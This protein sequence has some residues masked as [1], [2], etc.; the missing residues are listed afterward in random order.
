MIKHILK[1]V[2]EFKKVTLL[3]PVFVTFEVILDVSIPYLMSIIIDRGIALGNMEIIVK[4]GTVLVLSALLALFCGILSGRCAAKA[5]AGLAKNLRHDL[6]Y[7]IQDFSFSDIDKF[8]TS[9][10]VTRLTTD[11]TNV[12]IAYQMIIRVAIRSPLML[13][14]ALLMSF[15]INSQI[16]L[17]FLVAIPFMGL[18]LYLLMSKAQPIIE[19]TIKIYD[20][21]NRVVQENLLGIRVVKAYVREDFEVSKFKSVSDDISRK[22]T[23]ADRILSLN[24]PLMQFT[25]YSCSLIL[26]WFGAT[27]IISS[28]MSTGQLMSLFS[29]ISQILMGLMMISMVLTMIIV[30]RTSAKRIVEVLD[31]QSSMENAKAPILSVADG[32]INFQNV[33]FSYTADENKLS[34]KNINLTINAGETIGIIGSTGSAKTTLIQLIPRLYE[35][36]VGSISVGGID[37][38][39]Y[40]LEVLRKSVAVV[41]QQNILFSGTIKENLRWGNKLAPDKEMVRVCK[42]AQ[43]DEF[44]RT[45]PKGY[46]TYIDQG[47]TNVSGGQKQRLCIARALLKKPQILIL[48]DSTSSVD[49]KTDE[50]IR[51]ALKNDTPHITKIIIAQRLS[52]IQDCDRIIVMD[53]GQIN[54]VG[55]HE[56]LIKNN[57]IYQEVYYSQLKGDTDGNAA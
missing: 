2:R 34:L 22:F 33:S 30:S 56:E 12:Q 50:L 49:T 43:A 28:T 32:S 10:L 19:K 13:L 15:R 51:C 16:A 53:A 31:T 52:S 24:S 8:S 48:D 36:T 25:M 26:S 47:G 40:D 42:I 6:Y 55:T 3:T 14:F 29:Y 38:R 7:K 4:M 37:V 17:I 57:L 54:E 35:V 20:S 23:K 45:F 21:L 44:I 27:M 41:L 46:D 1:S 9:S 18:G 5:A 39:K 11:I